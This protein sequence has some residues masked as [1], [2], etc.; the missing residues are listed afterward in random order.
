MV[1]FRALFW[2]DQVIVFLKKWNK[3]Q[4]EGLDGSRDTETTIGAA[5]GDD[6]S[7]SQRVIEA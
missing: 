3:V 1:A 7:D 4:V 2:D 5:R 6:R